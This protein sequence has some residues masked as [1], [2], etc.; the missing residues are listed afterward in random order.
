MRTPE[1]LEQTI[2]YT[3]QDPTRLKLALVHSSTHRRHKDGSALDNERLEFLGDR[4]LG[5][6]IADLLFKRFPKDKEGDLARRHTALV[7]KEALAR[8]STDIELGQYIDMLQAEADLG[9]RENPAILANA[10]EAVIAALFQDGGLGAAQ[11]FITKFWAGLVEEDPTPPQDNKTA[12]QEWAQSKGLPLPVYKTVSQTGPAHAPIF[13]IE[14][15]VK[16]HTPQRAS[17][18]SKRK[19]E[20]AAAG[21]LLDIVLDKK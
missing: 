13:E 11:D 15:L 4:V 20:Q 17:G 2:G 10:C 14:V 7:R 1:Q 5:L 9:G 3:F 6:V 12:L 21:T 18:P 16:N 8:V 19:A